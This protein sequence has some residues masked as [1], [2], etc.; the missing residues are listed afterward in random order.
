MGKMRPSTG[1]RPGPFCIDDVGI[2]NVANLEVIDG[3]PLIS[4][5]PWGKR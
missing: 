2:I 5:K 1:V 4:I 3:T